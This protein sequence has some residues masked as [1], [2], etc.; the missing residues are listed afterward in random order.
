MLDTELGRR[1]VAAAALNGWERTAL[2]EQFGHYGKN[3]KH[4]AS[5]LARDPD[6]RPD[7]LQLQMLSN[8]LG[9]PQ[10]RFTEPDWQRLIKSAKELAE[11][12]DRKNR[13]KGRDFRRRDD[14][15]DQAESA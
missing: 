14:D 8:V 10:S 6:A 1:I 7:E 5:R 9:V 13:R 4:A 3:V 15:E 2:P 11:D 12:D